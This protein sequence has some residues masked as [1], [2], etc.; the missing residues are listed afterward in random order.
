[1]M[2]ETLDN[3][4][5]RL[6]PIAWTAPTIT[7]EMNTAIRA[8]SIV[9]APD[10]LSQ[11]RLITCVTWAPISLDAQRPRPMRL[12]RVTRSAPNGCV[13]L[14]CKLMEQ[15]ERNHLDGVNMLTV[16]KEQIK[17]RHSDQRD[18]HSAKHDCMIGAVY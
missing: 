11:N 4:V 10:S 15:V 14:A 9:V 6:V 18:R 7:I 16:E 5:F 13:S 1:M 8:Y 12:R 2:L 3:V 17:G